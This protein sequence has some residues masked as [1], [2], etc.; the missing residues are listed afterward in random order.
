MKMIGFFL[1]LGLLAV[2][3]S[4]AP[5]SARERAVPAADVPRAVREAVRAKYGDA[6]IVGY[7]REDEHGATTYEVSIKRSGSAVDV[8]VSPAGRILAEEE[9]IK[10]DELPPEVAKAFATSPFGGGQVR[11]VERIAENQNGEAPRFEILVRSRGQLVELTFD[12][13]GTLVKQEKLRRAD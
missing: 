7:T 8:S 13:H 1:G 6:R 9:R 3:A 11:R 2:S 10:I 12:D 5:L 4:V